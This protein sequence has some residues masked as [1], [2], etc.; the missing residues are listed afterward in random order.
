MN[1]RQQMLNHKWTKEALL[2]KTNKQKRPWRTLLEPT[3]T[4][5]TAGHQ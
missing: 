2:Q 5:T 3:V 4:N 1:T